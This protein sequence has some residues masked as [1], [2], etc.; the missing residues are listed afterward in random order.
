MADGILTNQARLY[1]P[2][3]RRAAMAL[4][5][6]LPENVQGAA[7]FADISG[8]TPLTEA[9]TGCI[10]TAARCRRTSAAPECHL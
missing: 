1:I 5:K 7:L 3:D 9:L 2:Q 4:G 8:F 6:D 10:G